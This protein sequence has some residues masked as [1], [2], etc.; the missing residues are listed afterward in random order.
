MDYLLQSFYGDTRPFSSVTYEASVLA[1]ERA[2]LGVGIAWATNDKKTQLFDETASGVRRYELD[3]SGHLIKQS[4]FAANSLYQKRSIDEQGHTR[5]EVVDKRGRLV[6]RQQE[7]TTGVYLTTYY[8]YDGLDR[9]RAV[10]QPE[11]YALNASINRNSSEWQ[12]WVFGYD[13]DSKGRLMAKHVPGGGWTEMVYDNYDR[14]AWQRTAL[15]AELGVGPSPRWSFMKYDALN[16]VIATGEK[17]ENSDR[18]TLQTAADGS[19]GHHEDRTNSGIFYTL[20]NSYPSV[21]EADVRSVQYFGDYTDW[22]PNSITFDG[23]N[24]YHSQYTNATG[25]PTGSRLRNSENQNWLVSVNYYDNK[26]RVIQSFAQNLYGQIERQDLEYNFAGEINKQRQIHKDQSGNS[27]PQLT[28]H[29]YDHVGRKTTLYQTINNGSREKLATYSYDE[30]G[31]QKQKKIYPDRAYQQYGSTPEYIYRPPSPVSNTQDLATQ[32]IILQPNTKID[33]LNV[34]TYVAQIGP[35][36]SLGTVQALQTVDYNYHIRGML[37]CINCNSN[38]PALTANQND[39][40]DNRLDFQED[41][42][43]YDGNIR[44]ETWRS[45][46]NTGADRAYTYSYDTA[47]RITS[48]TYTGGHCTAEDFG[49]SIGSYDR[50]GNI[51]TLIRKGAR[52]FTNESPSNFGNID[53]LTYFYQGN[54]LTGITDAISGNDDVGDFR[55][56]GVPHNG[57]NSD[58][59]YW[60]DGSLKSDANRGISQINW[61]TFLN[62]PR[63][64][65]YAD[66]RSIRFYYDGSGKKL[67]QSAS[68][69]EQIDYTKSAIYQNSGSGQPQLYQIAQPEGRI[70]PDGNGGFKNQFD[71][72]DHLGNL[73]L[74]F[75]GEG[76]P[77]SGIYPAPTI[78]QENTYYP[79]GLAHTGTDYQHTSPNNFQYNGK[80]K[81]TEL[82]SLHPEL[83]PCNIIDGYEFHHKRFS[84]K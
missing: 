44:K 7:A 67:R 79:F 24:A 36:T 84:K 23:G 26:G 71:Y 4:D 27:T 61:D 12:Q 11:G 41:G 47:K 56:G 3:G 34:G 68:T 8:I 65:N 9:L 62:K 20:T 49:F 50:N 72:K 2:A 69:G 40:F 80:E 14:L 76:T 15:Q 37:S 51:N 29:D 13:Y 22:L 16:R 18:A 10:L 82:I 83:F 32:A 70:V 46:L 81:L 1:R 64:I 17:S 73:R 28:E 43:Y 78:V 35:R 5:L 54:R 75:E 57:S 42:T 33:A 63:E 66:E 30:L 77:I 60:D 45:I 58:Y 38:I 31:R 6:Q 74:V 59:T 48:A 53:Q 39:F 52:T 21:S 19:S 55:A 25:L